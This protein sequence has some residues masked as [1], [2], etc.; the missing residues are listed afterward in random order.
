MNYFHFQ[1][2]GV[3]LSNAV[4]DLELQLYKNMKGIPFLQ[5][6]PCLNKGVLTAVLS[7][8]S[9]GVP[10]QIFGLQNQELSSS[11]LICEEALFYVN[12]PTS[13]YFK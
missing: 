13:A 11:N 10:Q 6:M 8:D 5:C 2:V 3:V 1:T 4:G 9:S 7:R 12:P